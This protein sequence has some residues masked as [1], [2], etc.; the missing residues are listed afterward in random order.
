MRRVEKLSEYKRLLELAVMASPNL[1]DGECCVKQE[2][3][4]FRPLFETAVG[5][6]LETSNIRLQ[7]LEDVFERRRGRHSLLDREAETV[8]LKWK[9]SRQSR[10]Y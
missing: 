1:H 2:N 4:L 6:P 7:F 3:A 10:L 5:R 8:S 9:P